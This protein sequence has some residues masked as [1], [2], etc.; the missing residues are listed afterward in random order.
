MGRPKTY[1]EALRN[2]LLDEASKMLSEQG[3]R[4]VSLR[5]VTNRAGTS[6]NAVYTLFGSKEALMAE[7]ILRDLDQNLTP[8]TDV[9]TTE[10]LE[11]E[12]LRLTREVRQFALANPH[13]FNGAFDAMAE[14]REHTSLTDRINPEVRKIDQR[15]FLPLLELTTRIANANPA[16]KHNPE[17]MAITL[18][19]ALHGYIVLETARILPASGEIADDLFDELVYVVYM[20]WTAQDIVSLHEKFPRLATIVDESAEAVQDRK[21]PEPQE[22]TEVEETIEVEEG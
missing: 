14:A 13:V 21:T 20:G 7:V 3:Y 18:W 11:G 2:R 17:R 15:L 8:L 10:D 1:D 22:S 16:Q 12:L 9:T 6:T 4:N 5:T 19:A